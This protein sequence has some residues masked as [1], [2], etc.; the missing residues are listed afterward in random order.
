[1]MMYVGLRLCVVYKITL[2]ALLPCPQ[3]ICGV[4]LSVQ[5][6]C[7]CVSVPVRRLYLKVFDGSQPNLVDVF[8]ITQGGCD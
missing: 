1:M 7:L 6:V 2:E 3:I 5:V 8:P 4:L